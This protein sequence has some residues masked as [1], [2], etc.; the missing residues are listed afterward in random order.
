M[1]VRPCITVSMPRWIIPS[2]NVSTLL[3]ASS[4]MNSSGSAKMARARLMS[5]FCPVESRH[6]ALAH[7]FIKGPC[8]SS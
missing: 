1:L 2:V 6:A 7:L 5:C 4:M 8:R 3:V